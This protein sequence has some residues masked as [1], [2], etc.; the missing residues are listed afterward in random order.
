MTE[1]SL[2]SD[3]NLNV[4]N[5]R[6]IVHAKNKNNVEQTIS[7]AVRNIT[8]VKM[9]T[10]AYAAFWAVITVIIGTYFLLIALGII[11]ENILNWNFDSIFSLIFSLSI[12]GAGLFW[13]FNCEPTY[14]VVIISSAGETNVLSSQNKEYILKITNCINEAIILCQ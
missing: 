8:S 5:L 7:Y 9:I 1:K 13:F 12:I 6:I 3:I 10:V 4:T 14:S 11:G 2:Y